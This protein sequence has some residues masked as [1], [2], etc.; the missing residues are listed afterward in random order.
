MAI[1]YAKFGGAARCRFFAIRE[2]NLWGLRQPPCRAGSG[3]THTKFEHDQPSRYS[4]DKASVFF[5]RGI[6]IARANP[7]TPLLPNV[8]FFAE[9]S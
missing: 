5:F 7:Y 9:E 2:K 8:R 3:E 4:W 1:G 6:H